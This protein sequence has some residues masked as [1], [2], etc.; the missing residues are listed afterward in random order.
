M[1]V[2]AVRLSGFSIAALF[3]WYQLFPSP[4]EKALF[5]RAKSVMTD[6]VARMD[7]GWQL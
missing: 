3:R 6:A 4:P 1:M 7:T 2:T 5:C